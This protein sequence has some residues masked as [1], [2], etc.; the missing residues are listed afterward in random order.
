M[1]DRIKAYVP[2]GVSLSESLILERRE[3][4]ARNLSIDARWSGDSEAAVRLE[5][6]EK[7]AR[8]LSECARRGV[9]FSEEMIQEREEMEA[10]L[11]KRADPSAQEDTSHD[12]S[13]RELISEIMKNLLSGRVGVITPAL[14]QRSKFEHWLKWE[15]I[16]T[17]FERGYKPRSEDNRHDVGFDYSG[18]HYYVELKTANTNWRAE[19]IENKTRPITLNIKQ[20]CDDINKVAGINSTSNRALVAFCLFP[21][22]LRIYADKFSDLYRKHIHRIEQRA[23]S[24]SGK[25]NWEYVSVSTFEN[26]GLIVGTVDWDND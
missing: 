14:V 6:Y 12:Q 4:A 7:L 22:P 10:Y 17:L 3:R 15:L 11:W 5:R 9:P 2:E 8:Y 18:K 23:M 13:A 25:L 20:I 26:V 24:L 21:V 1:P 16:S 19:G